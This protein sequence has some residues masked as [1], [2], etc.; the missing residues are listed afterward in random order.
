MEVAPKTQFQMQ[1]QE[2]Q[3]DLTFES[4]RVGDTIQDFEYS[5]YLGG[6]VI[7]KEVNNQLGR[8]VYLLMNTNESYNIIIK[9]SMHGVVKLQF[10]SLDLINQLKQKLQWA[11]EFHNNKIDNLTYIELLYKLNEYEERI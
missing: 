2:D 3:K 10:V 8:V 7:K 9:L 5:N 4:L 6:I 11:N 1:I